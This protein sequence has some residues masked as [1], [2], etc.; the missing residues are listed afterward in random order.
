MTMLFAVMD[1]LLVFMCASYT[2]VFYDAVLTLE[3]NWDIVVDS[4]AKG[5]I[6]DV[7][8]LDCCRPFLEV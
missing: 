5:T 7:Y 6:P 2:S 8:D 4:V 3:E 1:P